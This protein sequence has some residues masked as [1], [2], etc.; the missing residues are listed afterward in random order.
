[1]A[2]FSGSSQQKHW[3]F[4][5]KERLAQVA[6]KQCIQA[7]EEQVDHYR[8]ICTWRLLRLCRSYEMPI[9]VEATAATYFRR[10]FL[11]HSFSE[12]DRHGFSIEDISHACI[13]LACKTCEVRIRS[14]LSDR[15]VG[16]KQV[17][18]VVLTGLRFQLQVH[19][20]YLA[21]EG[22]LFQWQQMAPNLAEGI[23]AAR[24]DVQAAVRDILL[25]DMALRFTPAQLALAALQQLLSPTSTADKAMRNSLEDFISKKV[26]EQDKTRRGN[27]A[28]IATELAQFRAL[29]TEDSLLNQSSSKVFQRFETKLLGSAK[30]KKKTTK[31]RQ[32]TGEAAE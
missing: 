20:P 1:M 12:A 14:A 28:Q 4:P 23:A 22:F 25:T 32:R 15:F 9:E 3:L 10:Y 29:T 11:T 26:C 18:P 27:L 17:E 31:K 19:H 13:L 21:L 30:E 6:A 5:S 16:I 24:R 2:A 8:T 7:R